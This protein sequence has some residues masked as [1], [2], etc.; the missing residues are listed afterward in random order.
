MARQEQ[1]IFI[2]DITGQPGDD[3]LPVDFVVDDTHYQIDLSEE[4]RKE[5]AAAFGGYVES[6]R[7]VGTV[8]LKNAQARGGARP[9]TAA[10]AR[11]P[12]V[13]REQNQ[14]VREWAQ[15]QGMKISERG[16]IPASVLDA[17][18]QAV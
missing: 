3:V 15:K 12:V 4:S 2:D 8:R 13:D 1:V 11:R 14:A 10:P 18:H 9:A 5:F 6:A 17:Y 7:R 16:R